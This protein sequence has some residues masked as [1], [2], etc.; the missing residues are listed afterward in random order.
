MIT[1]A[2]LRADYPEFNSSTTYPNS[3]ISYYLNLAYIMLDPG[4]WSTLLDTGAELFVAHNLVLEARAQAESANG[5]LPG[6]EVGVLSSKSVGGV[7]IS[8]DTA[9]G[10][11]K[12]AG[13]WNLTI[14]GTRL[15]RLIN[16]L[17]AGPIQVGIGADPNGL[18]GPAWS[19]PDVTPGFSNF[20]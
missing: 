3:T 5:S 18:N 9:S 2:Q 15:K 8:Y 16:V 20:S 13:H 1:A 19:G 10:V 14:Y 4:R 17:G 12:D 11:E 6:R 7:S